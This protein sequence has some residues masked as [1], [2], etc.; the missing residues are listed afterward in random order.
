MEHDTHNLAKAIVD[1]ATAI[2]NTNNVHELRNK[3]DRM[4]EKLEKLEKIMSAISDQLDAVQQALTDTQTAVDS[5]STN[6]D[7]LSTDSATIIAG[8]AALDKLI[9]DFQKSP[10]VLSPEDQ[11]RLDDVQAASKTLVT[12]AQGLQSKVAAVKT[13][14]DAIDT[15]PPVAPTP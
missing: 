2:Q 5:I 9:T 8:I 15:T 4:D 13:A 7:G 10:G 12:N 1:L 6:V 11:K 14:V 3:L